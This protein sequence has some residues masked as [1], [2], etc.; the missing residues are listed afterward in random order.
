[1]WFTKNCI[2][3]NAY[4]RMNCIR[5][6]DTVGKFLD[7]RSSLKK[8]TYK[9]GLIPIII[10]YARK[11]LFSGVFD[12]VSIFQDGGIVM[13]ETGRNGW[14][15]HLAQQTTYHVTLYIFQQ[16]THHVIALSHRYGGIFISF[17]S[18]PYAIIIIYNL[19]INRW[20]E[21]GIIR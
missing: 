4:A 17:I 19:L 6:I 10:R 9:I 16:F 11:V 15:W 3:G 8:N 12:I 1:M 18:I 5:S 7:Y 14:N 13:D 20:L 2:S 21:Y